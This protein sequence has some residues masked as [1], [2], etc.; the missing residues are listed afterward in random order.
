MEINLYIELARPHAGAEFEH[1][2]QKYNINIE[3][4]RSS[5]TQLILPVYYRDKQLIEITLSFLCTIT[6]ELPLWI[7]DAEATWMLSLGLR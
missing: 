3:V 2:S 4:K 1:F 5:P 7:F 6:G